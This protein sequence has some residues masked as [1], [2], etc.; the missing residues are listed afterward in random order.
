M[1]T[2]NFTP[3]APVAPVM[4]PPPT[5]LA[6]CAS[7]D[8]SVRYRPLASFGGFTLADETD[9]LLGIGPNGRPVCPNG[10]GEMELAD[11]RLPIEQAMEQV[12]EK[13]AEPQRLPYPSPPFNYEGALHEIF[14]MEQSNAILESKFNDADER[15]KKAKAALDDG[16][17]KLSALIGTLQEREQDRLHEIARREAAKAAGHP[18]ETNLVRC[19]WEEAHPDETC[20]LCFSPA[21]ADHYKLGDTARDSSL[22]IEAVDRLIYLRDTDVIVTLLDGV[23]LVISDVTVNAWSVEDRETVKA[24]ADAPV[25]QLPRPA[26]LGTAHVASDVITSEADGDTWQACRECNARI[27]SVKTG[28]DPEARMAEEQGYPAGT[29]VGVDCEGAKEPARYAKRGKRAKAAK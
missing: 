2:E 26:I 18:E 7:C 6:R 20:P 4:E 19:A 10:H 11:D 29:L 24:W 14:E 9:L 5:H 27:W 15:R 28:K 8:Y 25:E 17:S 1:N 12:A 21:E 13:L 3:D 22:H 23:G 16:R